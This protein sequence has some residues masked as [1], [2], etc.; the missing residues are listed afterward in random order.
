MYTSNTNTTVVSHI[1]A[2]DTTVR[3][4]GT[5]GKSRGVSSNAQEQ[6]LG[7]KQIASNEICRANV[8]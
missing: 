2:Y 4:N 5:F 7:L 1:Y 6:P 8:L 3:L